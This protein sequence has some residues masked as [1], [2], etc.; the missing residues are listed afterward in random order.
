MRFKHS[1]LY[2]Y[3]KRKLRKYN[4]RKGGYGQ[5]GQDI[6]VAGL[7]ENRDHGVFVDIGANDGVSLS[8]TLYFEEKGWRGVCVE[9]HPIIF[10]ELAKRRSCHTINACISDQNTEVTF[11]AVDGPSHMLSG[12]TEFIDKRHS[13]RIEKEIAINGGSK[14]EIAIQALTPRYLLEQYKIDKID[15]LSID[16]EG[17]ELEILK[18]FDFDST[19]VECISVENGSRSSQIFKHLVSAGFSIVCCVGCDEIYLKR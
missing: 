1:T 2:W 16:T 4:I 19:S 17:C 14:R 5:Y 8:N 10:K 11:L 3:F 9:P 13:E 6:V 7:L 18:N 15:F 12:I